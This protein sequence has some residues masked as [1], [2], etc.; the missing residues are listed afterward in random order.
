VAHHTGLRCGDPATLRDLP[1]ALPW[2][3]DAFPV[4]S[5]SYMLPR[6]NQSVGSKQGGA[7]ATGGI[8]GAHFRGDGVRHMRWLLDH[9]DERA[10]KL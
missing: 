4:I 10:G 5:V 6:R 9:A 2:Q 8:S 7:D 1:E 3:L